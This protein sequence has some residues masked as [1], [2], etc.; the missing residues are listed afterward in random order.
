MKYQYVKGRI[1]DAVDELCIGS[2]D[3]LSRLLNANEATISLT[4]RNS[5]GHL[6]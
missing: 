5:G 6:T 2:G 4:D 3:A 1:S